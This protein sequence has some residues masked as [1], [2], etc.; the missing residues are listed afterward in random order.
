MTWENVL[1][2]TKLSRTNT[3]KL[4]LLMQDGEWRTIGEILEALDLDDSYRQRVIGKLGIQRRSRAGPQYLKR[5]REVLYQSRSG[6]RRKTV[7]EYRWN[8]SI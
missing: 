3:Q 5:K 8:D 7:Y 2:M 1:K 4:V 6:R